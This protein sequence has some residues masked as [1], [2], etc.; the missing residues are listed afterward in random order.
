MTSNTPKK[1]GVV[2]FTFGVNYGCD[3][4]R[5]ALQ[6]ACR[7][8]GYQATELLLSLDDLVCLKRPWSF[9][10]LEA[11]YK[12]F[13]R[14]L[15]AGVF[16]GSQ[17][18]RRRAFR[19][20]QR[21]FLS[22][23]PRFRSYEEVVKKHRNFEFQ[24][25][26]AGSD[27]IWN[28][29][30]MRARHSYDYYML[31]FVPSEKRI[32]Y[33]PSVAVSKIAEEFEPNFKRYLADF[34]FLSAREQEGAQEL[35]RILNRPV[36]R[37]LDPTFLLEQEDWNVLAD[38]ATID[39]PERYVLCYSLGNLESLLAKASRLQERL[40]A[41]ILCFEDKRE[42]ERLVRRSNVSNVLFARNV[43]PCEFVKLIKNA[44]C[45]V[46][47]SYHGSVFSIIYRRPFFTMMRDRAEKEE[48]MNSRM[49]TLFSFLGLESRLFDP[50]DESLNANASLEWDYDAVES[51]LQTR[52]EFSYA[53]LKNALDSATNNT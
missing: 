20:F 35:T 38:A 16:F 19:N 25:Y 26:I 37:T 13:R 15:R 10:R 28:P 52:R 34:P 41:P 14:D 18:R 44:T 22:R 2:S 42:T 23:T 40:Q 12:R 6:Q 24:A 31:A 9:G 17:R 45:V 30:G 11:L 46:T 1:V 53:Y 51:Y 4:Q 21:R 39:A 27:Q 49:N 7:R 32:A 43:G 33:A 36:E 29:L 48:S 50:N 47:D 8:L 3:L 5:Y